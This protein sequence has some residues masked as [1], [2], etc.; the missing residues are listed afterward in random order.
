MQK[1]RTPLDVECQLQLP[2]GQSEDVF[3]WKSEFL[4][5]EINV[6]VFSAVGIR[7]KEKIK[8]NFK[9]SFQNDLLDLIKTRV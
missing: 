5:S 8:R 9:I 6:F 1:S 3:W 2:L 4:K 7:S